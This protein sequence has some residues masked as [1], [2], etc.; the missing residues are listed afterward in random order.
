V[1]RKKIVW[2]PR[3]ERVKRERDGRQLNYD[4]QPTT[5]QLKRYDPDRALHAVIDNACCGCGLRHLMAFEVFQDS[6]GRFYLNKRSYR[7]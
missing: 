5:V 2:P 4:G 7:I 3:A 6:A 1:S